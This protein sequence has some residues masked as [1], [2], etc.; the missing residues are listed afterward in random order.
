MELLRLLAI[1]VKT[2]ITHPIRFGEV[3]DADRSK[4]AL[5][6]HTQAGIVGAGVLVVPSLHVLLE[7]ALF[8]DVSLKSAEE[9]RGRKT[10][11]KHC[12]QLVE[13]LV[14]YE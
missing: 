9:Q 12:S 13:A 4:V 1:E 6:A 7:V 3:S 14:Y 10:Q 11:I 8:C 2:R 5:D